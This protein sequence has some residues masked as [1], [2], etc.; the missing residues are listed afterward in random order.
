M[1]QKKNTFKPEK[2][3]SQEQRVKQTLQ[4][5]ERS[6]AKRFITRFEEVKLASWRHFL[7]PLEPKVIE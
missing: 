2:V 7:L 4:E 3:S 6:E 1:T 5:E